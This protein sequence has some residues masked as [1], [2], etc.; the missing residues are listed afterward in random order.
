MNKRSHNQGTVFQDAST[1]RWIA[2]VS[3]GYDETGKR[4]RIRRKARTKTE[5]LGKLKDMQ[6]QVDDGVPT[7]RASMT[8][9]DLLDFFLDTVVMSR[10]PSVNTVDNYKWTYSPVSY[11]HLTL[12]TICSV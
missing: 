12:P 11:T 9:S 8:I 1:G 6:R 7:G 4:K 10:D 3:A 2:E 5:A